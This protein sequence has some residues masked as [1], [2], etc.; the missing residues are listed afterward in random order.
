MKGSNINLKELAQKHS[1]T[2]SNK[3]FSKMIASPI[4]P[5][6]MFKKQVSSRSFT[7]PKS[8]DSKTTQNNNEDIP[9]SNTKKRL[10]SHKVRGTKNAMA[11]SEHLYNDAFKRDTK[12]EQLKTQSDEEQKR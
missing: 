8:I 2:V 9:L 7:S 3:A 12:R 11:I 10:S 6:S 4:M 5:V 1:L